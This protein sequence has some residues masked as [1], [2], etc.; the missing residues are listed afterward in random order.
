MRTISG[1]QVGYVAGGRFDPPF[2]PTKQKPFV[3]G[4]TLPV[5]D[6]GGV[7]LLTYTLPTDAELI[8][9]A[10]GCSRYDIADNWDVRVNGEVICE[11]IYTKDLPEGMYLMAILQLEAGDRIDFYYHADS[12]VGKQVWVNYQMLKD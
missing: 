7:H 4:L 10:C 6:G 5:P 3:K 2:Y 1:F 8:S 12:G 9:I 11:S